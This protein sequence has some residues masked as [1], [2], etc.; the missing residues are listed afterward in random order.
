MSTYQIQVKD[1]TGDI[2]MLSVS[3]TD[4]IYNIKEQYG[5]TKNISASEFDVVYS[6]KVLTNNNTLNDYE[7]EENSVLHIAPKLKGGL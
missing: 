1:S 2:T 4:T 5:E 3:S 6:G 7:I